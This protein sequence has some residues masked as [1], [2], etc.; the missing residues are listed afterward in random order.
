M[1]PKLYR[2]SHC[3]AVTGDVTLESV[4]PSELAAL[5]SYHIIPPHP[6]IDAVWTTPFFKASDGAEIDT[7]VPDAPLTFEATG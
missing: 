4:P 2:D 5:L 1:L 7:A 6:G 3:I